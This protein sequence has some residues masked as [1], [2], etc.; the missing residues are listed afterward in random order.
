ML[1]VEL[2]LLELVPADEDTI[3]GLETR[4][5]N[6]SGCP[7]QSGFNWRNVYSWGGATLKGKFCNY[8]VEHFTASSS[9]GEPPSLVREIHRA[10][11]RA[12]DGEDKVW[13]CATGTPS[14]R[15]GLLRMCRDQLTTY[16]PYLAH[17][18]FVEQAR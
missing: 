1:V 14:H 9:L 8:S 15:I 4:G 10:L 3:L 7:E 12:L 18:Q 17:A 5:T 11:A 2:S 16:V 6:R 13:D